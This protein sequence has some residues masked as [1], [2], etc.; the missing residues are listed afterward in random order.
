MHSKFT[1]ILT[2]ICR[3]A[4]EKVAALAIIIIYRNNNKI[5]FFSQ[6]LLFPVPTKALVNLNMAQDFGCQS[7]GVNQ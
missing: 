6:V 2:L 4:N 3:Y 7:A 5:Q 1:N